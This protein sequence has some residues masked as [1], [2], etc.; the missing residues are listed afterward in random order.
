VLAG[1]VIHGYRV[2]RIREP[3][4]WLAG[5]N[6]ALDAIDPS[7]PQDFCDLLCVPDNKRVPV[8]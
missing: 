5:G 8:R 4:G 2:Y 7:T 1:I 6:F 3:A